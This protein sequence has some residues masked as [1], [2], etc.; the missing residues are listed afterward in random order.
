MAQEDESVGQATQ[1]QTRTEACGTCNA[2]FPFADLRAK[3]PGGSLICL[4]CFREQRACL[5]GRSSPLPRQVW[6]WTAEKDASP[7]RSATYLGAFISPDGGG[8]AVLL[9]EEIT[10]SCPGDEALSRE[11]VSKVQECVDW[12]ELLN[13]LQQRGE[14]DEA[15]PPPRAFTAF[16]CPGQGFVH[17]SEHE[18]S[19]GARHATQDL[20]TLFAENWPGWDV[21]LSPAAAGPRR[22][23]DLRP[24]PPT[25]AASGDSLEVPILMVEGDLDT[26]N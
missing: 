8:Y 5:A 18:V 20:I 3:G 14:I 17:I 6:F 23:V 12:M 11:I 16:D 13:R 22:V 4:L 24:P 7:G 1:D 2:E 15:P 10:T 9:H 26:A 21:L 19:D 25:E